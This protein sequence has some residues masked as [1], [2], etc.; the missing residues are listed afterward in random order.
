MRD[1][2]DPDFG[3]LKALRTLLRR[4]ANQLYVPGQDVD[5][6]V[7]GAL[8]ALLKSRE[9]FRRSGSDVVAWAY[10]VMRHDA[11]DQRR[12]HRR[13]PF[14]TT[15]LFDAPMPAS[16]FEVTFA[17]Q[18]FAKVEA[19]QPQFRDAIVRE[20]LGYGPEDFGVNPN[21]HRGRVSRARTAL[22]CA[23]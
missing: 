22:E 8:E 15:E 11:F 3:D 12:R 16:Q 23:A 18:M 2:I 4:R 7:Q 20:A 5:D 13:S 6:L 19:L 1:D 21:T 17:H 14:V 10:V 9:A